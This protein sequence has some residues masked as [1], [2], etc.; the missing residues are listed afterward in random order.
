MTETNFSTELVSLPQNFGPVPPGGERFTEWWNWGIMLRIC[1]GFLV[2]SPGQFHHSSISRTSI[3]KNIV[4]DNDSELGGKCSEF[5][6]S[7]RRSQRD[8]KT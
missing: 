7:F 2:E 6:P 1:L 3:T 8:D 5:T 4:L